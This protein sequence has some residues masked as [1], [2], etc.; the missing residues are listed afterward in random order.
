MRRLALATAA[1]CLSAC[2]STVKFESVPKAQLT[3]HTWKDIEGAG[4]PLGETPLEVDARK[5][6]DSIVKMAAPGRRPQFFAFPG[7][8]QGTLRLKINLAESPSEGLQAG[9]PTDQEI[10]FAQVNRLN[11]QLMAVMQALIDKD[12][13]TAQELAGKIASANPQLSAP[14][15]LQGIA[16]LSAGDRDGA[17]TALKSAQSLDPEDGALNEMLKVL[18]E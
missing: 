13:K 12:Y 15:I 14:L 18:A 8:S 3:L 2:A 5:L 11:R 10:S 6:E 9:K 17:R 16:Q 1:L 7:K 4:K